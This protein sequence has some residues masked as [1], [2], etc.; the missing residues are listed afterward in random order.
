MVS[1][2]RT[3]LTVPSRS[4]R[5]SVPAPGRSS[6]A[7]VPPKSRPA[8][9]QAPS[10]IR[11]PPSAS[12]PPS[13]V[14]S[15]STA[16]SPPGR[17]DHPRALAVRSQPGDP[18]AGA[19]QP[20]AGG[21][22]DGV[23]DG[24]PATVGGHLVDVVAAHRPPPAQPRGDVEP[25]QLTRG[26]VED[27]ALAV[28]GRRRA[29]GRRDESVHRCILAGLP[30]SRPGTTFWLLVLC[31]PPGSRAQAS[32]EGPARPAPAQVRAASI[33]LARRCTPSSTSPGCTAE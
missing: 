7:M 14:S 22:G 6:K 2:S 21:R 31:S 18:A 12:E 10:F 26:G 33:A 20:A 15:I 30:E 16:A 32:R 27:G 23:A 28:L 11:V 5:Y 17:P 3:V 4:S 19:E 8:R 13:P 9:S 29:G 1:P 24:V 25:D